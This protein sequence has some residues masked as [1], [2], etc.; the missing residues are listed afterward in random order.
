MPFSV[1]SIDSFAKDKD[2]ILY[3]V[4]S[5]HRFALPPFKIRVGLCDQQQRI[6]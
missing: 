2:C 1:H 3:E 5:K 6:E 4:I